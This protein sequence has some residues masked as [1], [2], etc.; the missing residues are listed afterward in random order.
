MAGEVA[1]WFSKSTAA[2]RSLESLL[3]LPARSI[4]CQTVCTVHVDSL[5]LEVIRMKPL[6]NVVLL[7]CV[8]FCGIAHESNAQRPMNDAQTLDSKQQG[9]VLISA[10]TAKGELARLENALN[11]GLNAGLTVNEIKEVIVQLYAYTG[12]PRSLNAL[13]TFMDV[14]KE[15]KGKGI[16]ALVGKEASLLPAHKDRLQFGTEMQTKLVGQSVKGP[17]FEFA[18]AI[19]QFLKEHLFGDIFGRDNLDWKTR[20]LATISALAAL[21]GVESQLRS[22]F[23]VGLYNGLTTGQLTGLVVLIESNVGTKEGKAAGGLWQSVLNQREGKS[24]SEKVVSNKTVSTTENYMNTKNYGMTEAI[25]P[26]GDK[27]SPD[28]FS[29]TAWVNVLVP[30]DETGNYSVGNVVFEPGC[31]NNWHIHP[32]G[33]ILIVLEGQGWYQERGKPAR[34]IRKGDVVV[35]PSNVEHWHGAAKGNGL[36]HLAVTNN[37]KEGSVKWLEPVTDEEY[38]SLQ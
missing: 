4:F 35:I 19:D 23:S 16:N 9:I 17:V 26:K 30:K 14:L 2:L 18:P 15:R 6:R 28:Y 37:S 13:Q 34:A 25:F 38:N 27:A 33:Q 1:R 24:D 31:R 5:L 21:G 12:F 20:E 11:E 29:G 8:L 32:A 7:I 22:H 36:T 3:T 10:F